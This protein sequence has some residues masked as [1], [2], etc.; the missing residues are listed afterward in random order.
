MD[1]LFHLGLLFVKVNIIPDEE[2]IDRPHAAAVVLLAAVVLVQPVNERIGVKELFGGLALEF[3]FDDIV[4]F[5]VLE[6]FARR[7]REAELLFFGGRFGQVTCRCL[8]QRILGVGFVNA[9]LRGQ[10]GGDLEHLSVEERHAQLQ[11]VCHA[12][13]V[14]LEQ[15]VAGHPEVDVEILHLGHIVVA[16]AAVIVT[17]RVAFRRGGDGGILQDLLFLFEVIHIGVAD[18]ALLQRV[19]G[20]N[21]IVASLDVGQLARDGAQSLAQKVGDEP[22]I[23]AEHARIVVAGVAAEQL[24]GALTGEHDLDILTRQTRHKIERHAG[25]VGERLIHIILH[26][27]HRVPKFLARD[28]VGVV[29]YVDQLADGLRPADLVVF[30]AEVKADGKGLLSRKI[31]GNIAGIHAR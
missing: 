12:H 5:F 15:N 4:V 26:R 11:R 28:Q 9:Q 25:R 31:G 24:V 2:H 7:N 29:I 10:L 21:D 17:A 14:C 18:V 6:P 20:A 16:A 19:A 30:F 23:D 22:L 3:L 1:G 27:G 13:A 8:S